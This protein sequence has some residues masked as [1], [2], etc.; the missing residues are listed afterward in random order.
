MMQVPPIPAFFSA[1]VLLGSVI[2]TLGEVEG[3]ESA[4]PRYSVLGT[5]Y[6]LTTDNWQLT[7][8]FHGN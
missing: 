4:F 3:E 1:D 6:S 8:G 2:P 5:R 7:T